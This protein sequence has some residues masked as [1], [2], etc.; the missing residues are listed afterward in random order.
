MLSRIA[1]ISCKALD[2]SVLATA[3]ADDP[4]LQRLKQEGKF[5]FQEIQDPLSTQHLWYETTLGRN[6][7]YIPPPHRCRIFESTQN[8]AHPG[9]FMDPDARLSH[10]HVDIFGP[11]PHSEGFEYL[12]TPTELLYGTTLIMPGDFTD[13]LLIQTLQPFA[14]STFADKI[15]NVMQKIAYTRTGYLYCF[16]IASPCH[17][18]L[19]SV[20]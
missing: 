17:F 7:L 15:R 12:F 6:R 8:I 2:S 4:D 3:Q 9:T 20:S 14:D 1:T 13:P 10:V 18:N 16:L 5:T 19:L 11:L